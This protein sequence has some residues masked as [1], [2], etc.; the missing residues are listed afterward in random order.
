MKSYNT[1][2]IPSWNLKDAEMLSERITIIAV[3][4]STVMMTNMLMLG[5]TV[6]VSSLIPTTIR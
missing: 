3:I 1:I 5:Y 2:L 4:S 6:V